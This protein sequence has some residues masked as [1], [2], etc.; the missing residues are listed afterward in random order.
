MTYRFRKKESM[1]AGTRRIARE[2]LDKATAELRDLEIKLDERVHQVRKRMKKLRGLLR[3]V[4]DGIGETYS[5]ENVFF[6]NLARSLSSLRDTG[7]MLESAD[8]LIERFGDEECKKNLLDK[9]KVELENM[10]SDYIETGESVNR[11]ITDTVTKIKDANTRIS[12]WRL[13]DRGFDAIRGGFKRTYKRGLKAMAT[14]CGKPSAKNFHEWRK[15]VKYHWYHARLLNPVWPAKKDNYTDRLK[16]LSNYLG[17]NHDLDVLRE[18]LKTVTV[19]S[20]SAKEKQSIR[21]MIGLRQQEL[22]ENAGREGKLIY[23]SKPGKFCGNVKKW[24]EAWKN[25]G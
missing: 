22:I 12:T 4:R 25:S 18:T 23:A 14:A 20:L 21:E 9:F 2:E 17:D 24:F 15:R 6:R 19:Q 1:I 8:G 16:T 11:L 7:A 3:L 5:R 13:E 10:R